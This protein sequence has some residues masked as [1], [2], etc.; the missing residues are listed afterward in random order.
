MVI[1]HAAEL[2][3]K[4][5]A[6]RSLDEAKGISTR[7][8]FLRFAG[9]ATRHQRTGRLRCTKSDD[10]SEYVVILLCIYR[11]VIAQPLRFSDNTCGEIGNIW[12]L[13][14]MQSIKLNLVV[15]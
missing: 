8:P 10:T 13:F 14:I 6:S 4:S 7:A 12:L 1:L 11:L 15:L 2:E 9:T 5:R 3:F